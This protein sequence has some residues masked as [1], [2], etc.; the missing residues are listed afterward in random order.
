MKKGGNVASMGKTYR[1]HFRTSAETLK[2]QAGWYSTHDPQYQYSVRLPGVESKGYIEDGVNENTGLL[3]DVPVDPMY[4]CYNIWSKEIGTEWLVD[5]TNVRLRELVAGYS[6]PG[7]ILSK[8]PVSGIQVS[9][10]GRNLFYFYDAMKDIDPESG[11]SSGNTGGAFEH[12]AIPSLRSM[13]FNIKI[14]F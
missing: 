2:G 14:G 5:G 6:V 3:N 1:A 12:C 7:K 8:T 10:V 4:R 13:D 9:F 11:Y